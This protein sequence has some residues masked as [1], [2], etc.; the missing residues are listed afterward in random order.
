MAVAVV[1]EDTLTRDRALSVCD[2]LVRQFWAE[3]D[4][5]I[6][7][8]REGYLADSNIAMAAASSAINA[9]LIVFSAHAEGELSAGLKTWIETWLDKRGDR[10][11]VLIGLIGTPQDAITGIDL[12]HR[13]LTQIAER[14]KLDYLSSILPMTPQSAQDSIGSIHRRAEKITSILAEILIYP[15]AQ[16]PTSRR[17]FED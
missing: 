10:E 3:V 13:Y 17:T 5:E 16:Q 9:D 8:W 12:K 7:W 1:Y 15:P 11:G 14:G 4:F 6:T 2:E